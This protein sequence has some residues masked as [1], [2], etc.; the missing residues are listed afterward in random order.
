MIKRKA[1]LFTRFEHNHLHENENLIEESRCS[2]ISNTNE[3]TNFQLKSLEERM[4]KL[5][6]QLSLIFKIHEFVFEF[7][8]IFERLMTGAARFKKSLNNY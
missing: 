1:T 2:P 4:K 6:E 3:S 8:M 5:A 7:F